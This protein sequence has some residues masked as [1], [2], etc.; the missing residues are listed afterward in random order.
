MTNKN[1]QQGFSSLMG[2]L[3][4]VIGFAVGVGSMWRFPYVT[5]TNGGALF[6][7]TYVLVIVLIGIPLLTAEIS[8]GYR[9][10]KTAVHAY[11]DL[12]PGKSWYLCGWLH[13]LVALL[14]FA[15][16][17]PI[18]AWILTYIWRTGTAFFA[19]LM[20]DAV[21][22]AFIGLTTDYKTMF[23]FAAINLGLIALVV[24][25][26]LE[27]G[28]ERLN[29]IL[30]PLLALI[31]VIC[32][33]IGLQYE[34]SNAGLAYLFKPDF[35]QFSLKSVTAAVGQAFFAIGIG[36]LASMVF[37]SYLKRKNA[38]VLRD[39]SVIS[40]AIVCAGIAAGLMIFPIVFAFGL[41]PSAGVGLTMITL[42]NVFNHMAGGQLVGVL[43]YV[44]FYFAAFTSAIGLCEAI[45]GVFMDVFRLSRKKALSIVM[46][47]AAVIGSCAIAVPGFLDVIDLVTSNYLLVISGFTITVFAGWVWGVDNMLDAASV[48]PPFLRA[49]LS[50]SVKYVCPLAILI[51]FL[52]NFF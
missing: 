10:Q 12:A 40:L 5:G 8:I 37:G 16:T 2:F 38:N 45:V 21:R 44:G 48:K 42:P 51:V 49:W 39:S 46:L 50:V 26:G 13:V 7:L 23:F 41:E 32:I 52:A 25:N 11:Q 18:Y 30:L 3:L 15:Y 6:I 19:G 43:F 47:F 22:D 4:S 34:G 1:N 17:L 24:K 29:M 9:S 14:V 27:N 36:M 31:V 33:V 35:S 28:I 20:P